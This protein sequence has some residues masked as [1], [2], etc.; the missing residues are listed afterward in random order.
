MAIQQ[1][2]L[3]YAA[4]VIVTYKDK[5]DVSVLYKKSSY[6]KLAAKNLDRVLKTILL[7]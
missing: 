1:T 5:E 6:A 7:G 2:A 3:D 4:L